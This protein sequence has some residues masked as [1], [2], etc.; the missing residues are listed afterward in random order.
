MSLCEICFV[1][2]Q[3]IVGWLSGLFAIKSFGKNCDNQG[4]P[5]TTLTQQN[6]KDPRDL[7]L[8]IFNNTLSHR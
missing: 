1:G 4:R 8:N 2:N 6:D 5:V 3:V 7:K